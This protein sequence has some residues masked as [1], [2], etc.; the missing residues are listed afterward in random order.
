MTEKN[1]SDVEA[2]V[3]SSA[4]GSDGVFLVMLGVDGSVVSASSYDSN[5][6]ST[7]F[8]PFE[9]ESWAGIKRFS[10]K[11]EA[12]VFAARLA[13]EKSNGGL[14]GRSGDPYSA[15]S[16]EGKMRATELRVNGQSQVGMNHE[17]HVGISPGKLPATA[18][19]LGNQNSMTHSSP[20][21][22]QGGHVL[23]T[24]PSR[25]S[26]ATPNPNYTEAPP[27]FTSPN[28]TEAPTDLS[29]VVIKYKTGS[30]SSGSAYGVQWE[31]S[32]GFPHVSKGTKYYLVTLK[33]CK[34][35][36]LWHMEAPFFESMFE[37]V[38]D[39]FRAN[40]WAV[41]YFFDTFRSLPIRDPYDKSGR[42]KRKGPYT[43]NKTFFVMEVPMN[44]FKVDFYWE[45]TRTQIHSQ[46]K[47][48]CDPPP[49]QLYVEWLQ[50]N[51]QSAYE[52]ETGESVKSKKKRITKEELIQSMNTKLI[53]TFGNE[54][55][56][57]W[58][59]P[60]DKYLSNYHIKEF[61]TDHC[62]YTGW[63]MVPQ[64]LRSSVY[65]KK[66]GQFPVWND[67]EREEY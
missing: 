28:Y 52:Y 26:F 35:G 29:K 50:A 42:Y 27:D 3:L 6:F 9:D 67:I 53:L 37:A 17:P 34:G 4:L 15:N 8:S 46:F 32:E 5:D 57:E 14:S 25:T 18:S 11:E 49:G 66:N 62:G 58:G 59:A 13:S 2:F 61:L 7:H 10:T 45:K 21:A 47:E 44:G 33:D 19:G 12:D 20:Q 54:I 56:P 30:L 31:I 55:K 39:A 64:S 65:H 43:V 40:N 38:A 48:T 51:K 23:E 1:K 41:P 63:E 16:L 22:N 60:L 36:N 24:P